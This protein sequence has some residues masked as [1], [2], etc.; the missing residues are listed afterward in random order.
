MIDPAPTVP[1]NL[2]LR[3]LLIPEETSWLAQC[4]EHDLVAR[5]DNPDAVV[6]AFISTLCV[7]VNSDIL[8]GI[9]PL[10]TCAPAGESYFALL[11][12]AVFDCEGSHAQLDYTLTFFLVEKLPLPEPAPDAT[13]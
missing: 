1:P 5:A 4:L 11:D 3:V 7:K 8:E 2:E 6:R 9:K 12:R 10:S 13:R